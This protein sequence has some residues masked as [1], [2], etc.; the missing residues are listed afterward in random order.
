MKEQSRNLVNQSIFWCLIVLAVSALSVNSAVFQ[1]TRAPNTL[2]ET[3]APTAG[4]NHGTLLHVPSYGTGLWKQRQI[5]I[6]NLN[7]L[8][9]GRATLAGISRI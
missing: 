7:V 9:L 6:F 4:T 5:V 8:V 3:F 2:I 1:D